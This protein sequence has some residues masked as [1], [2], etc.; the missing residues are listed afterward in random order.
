MPRERSLGAIDKAMKRISAR[1]T[2]ALQ[3]VRLTSSLHDG[4]INKLVVRHGGVQIKIEVTPV[5]RGCVY[6]PEVRPVSPAVE[7]QFGFAE[8]T[9][10]SLADLY[11]GKIVAALD[12]Q[13]PR[14]LFDVSDLLANEG[15][16]NELREAFIIYLISHNRPMSEVLSV[17][18]KDIKQE[19][20]ANF[21]GMT[22][23][24]VELETLLKA[25]TAITDLMVAGTNTGAF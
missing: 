18:P 5:L 15:V 8:M 12:R 6:A 10:V 21:R 11:A 22:A 2:R 16:T 7:E 13:H 4:A 3:D 19:F 23:E 20:E 1:L 9:V 17:W 25:R 14:D 24:P